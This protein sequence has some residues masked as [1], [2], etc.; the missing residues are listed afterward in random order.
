[1]KI[2]FTRQLLLIVIFFAMKIQSTYAGHAFGAELTY[3][4]YGPGPNT[5][6]LNFTFYRDCSG[7]T[8]PSSLTLQLTNTCGYPNQ[9]VNLHQVSNVELN[10][11]CQSVNSTCDSGSVVGIT[12]ITY[13]GTYTLA[14]P[15]EWFCYHS[16][17]TRA[18]SIT[19]LNTSGNLFTYCTINTTTGMNN[20]SAVFQ[21]EPVINVVSGQAVTINPALYDADGDSVHV[22]FI[23]PRTGPQ[24]ADTV[25]FLAGYSAQQPFSSFPPISLNAQSG[26]ISATPQA[27]NIGTYT[28]LVKEYR[29]GIF[30]GETS[31]DVGIYIQSLS[32]NYPSLSG[33]DGTPATTQTISAG[34]QSCFD[35]IS[36]DADLTQTTSIQ[37]YHLPDG[38][39]ITYAG[40]QPSTATICWTPTLAQISTTPYCFELRAQDD[41]CT[42]LGF[43]TKM[44]CITVSTPNSVSENNIA[45]TI[46]YPSPFH[47]ELILRSNLKECI[48]VAIHDLQ[49][50][51]LSS[52]II[53]ESE[54]NIDMSAFDSGIY[55][56]SA[57][58]LTTKQVQWQR[59]IK[60]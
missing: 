23:T 34:S 58:Q 31:H 50:R 29:N 37:N 13:S 21:A 45:E 19:T 35:V 55:L 26:E 53:C 15:C 32:N 17:S 24:A 57:T 54:S 60:Q 6:T 52:T 49:G 59:V 33:F 44:Y 18:T 11:H 1:M 46:A 20:T 36:T 5:Y 48:E 8:I 42:F 22:E 28:L 25:S 16:E 56:L 9:T 10:T 39:S 43:N 4:W 2:Q 40:G 3:S 47:N 14:G 7:I 51:K 27:L 12:K 38:M 41:N 30:L